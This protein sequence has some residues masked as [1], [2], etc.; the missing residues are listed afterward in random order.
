MPTWWYG[1]AAVNV[2]LHIKAPNTEAHW[3]QSRA[4]IV[5]AVHN[6]WQTGSVTE[7]NF[8]EVERINL[9]SVRFFKEEIFSDA[10]QSAGLKG[11][12]WW[13]F[14]KLLSNSLLKTTQSPLPQNWL[15]CLLSSISDISHRVGCKKK[16]NSKHVIWL[17]LRPVTNVS[18]LHNGPRINSGA[19]ALWWKIT[20]WPESSLHRL[21]LLTVK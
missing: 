12:F 14:I 3:G 21:S 7:T 11:S 18:H 16:N 17:T 8:D 6:Q 4:S 10:V 20:T 5:P 9:N 13:F 2:L 1:E 15:P 19:G